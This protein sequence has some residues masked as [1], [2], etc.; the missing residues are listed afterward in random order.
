[1][2][3][4]DFSSLLQDCFEQCADK[5]MKNVYAHA[6]QVLKLKGREAAEKYLHSKRRKLV[7][8]AAKKRK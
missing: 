4:D 8:V 1:M 7:R 2:T 5:E 6:I 3:T